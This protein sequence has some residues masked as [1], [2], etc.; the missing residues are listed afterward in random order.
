MYKLDSDI[1][2]VPG[3][4]SHV[5]E[6]VSSDQRLEEIQA[7]SSQEKEFTSSISEHIGS[8]TILLNIIMITYFIAPQQPSQELSELENDVI[9]KQEDE[10][11]DKQY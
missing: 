4:S 3:S 9:D 5:S 10:V 1:T 6:L 2:D 8:N 11:K 7:R